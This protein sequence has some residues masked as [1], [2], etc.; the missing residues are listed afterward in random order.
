[1]TRNSIIFHGGSVQLSPG[2]TYMGKSYPPRVDMT[3]IAKYGKADPEVFLSMV[4]ALADPKNKPFLEDLK[5]LAN[6]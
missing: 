2:G 6:S 5:Q 1:M 4:N 3:S